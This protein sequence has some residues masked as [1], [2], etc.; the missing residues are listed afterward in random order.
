MSSYQKRLQEIKHYKQCI[1]ELE[2]ICKDIWRRSELKTL[3]LGRGI[4]GDSYLTHYNT[5]GFYFDL[6]NIKKD[7]Q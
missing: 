3:P 7:K 5:G 1:E 4:A 6:I 2:D